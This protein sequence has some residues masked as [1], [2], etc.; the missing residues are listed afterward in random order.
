MVSADST[1]PT[2]LVPKP[3]S[4]IGS[5]E[6]VLG[7]TIRMNIKRKAAPN[8]AIKLVSINRGFS[9][10]AAMTLSARL[11][12]ACTSMPKHFTGTVI[13]FS[14]QEIFARDCPCS[15]KKSSQL[16]A[17]SLR[18]KLVT[19]AVSVLSFTPGESSPAKG[20]SSSFDSDAR[21]EDPSIECLRTEMKLPLES[22]SSFSRLLQKTMS[23]KS[24]AAGL[25]KSKFD[26]TSMLS[27]HLT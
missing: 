24:C 25:V 21:E 12:V 18:T 20:F 2:G 26:V 22:D 6:I 11:S 16:V 9:L 7:H 1:C 10:Q 13:S 5:L 4:T 8:G 14:V 15:S 19:P 3:G 27:F 23:K 17:V